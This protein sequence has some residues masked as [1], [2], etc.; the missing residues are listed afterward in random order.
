MKKKYRLKRNEEISSLVKQNKIKKSKSFIVYYQDN[1]Y[2]YS[3]I[4]ISVSKK[5]GNAV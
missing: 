4:C 3:R 5:L 1:E 2:D